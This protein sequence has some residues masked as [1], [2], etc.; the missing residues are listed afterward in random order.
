M[1]RCSAKWK[2]FF[3]LESYLCCEC[4]TILRM[5]VLNERLPQGITFILLTLLIH[6][7]YKSFY[8]SANSSH[9]TMT[10]HSDTNV[11][12][13][14]A[15]R[16]AAGSVQ[17]KQRWSE[18]LFTPLPPPTQ[19]NSVYQSTSVS[20]TTSTCGC[21]SS[22]E[23]PAWVKT[24][25]ATKLFSTL[26]LRRLSPISLERSTPAWTERRWN[27]SSMLVEFHFSRSYYADNDLCLQ[28]SFIAKVAER[29]ER[30]SQV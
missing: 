18:F 22:S 12:N 27:R 1:V 17:T 14:K 25:R 28:E 24:W 15:H 6:T 21:R 11:T 29:P 23:D 2:E 26:I 7:C 10:R 4:C 9:V 8:K 30:F 19:V 20:C 3:P 5:I 16:W 13:H